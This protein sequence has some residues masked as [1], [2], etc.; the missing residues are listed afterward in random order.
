[1]CYNKIQLS[2][3]LEEAFQR[4]GDF[5]VPPPAPVGNGKLLGVF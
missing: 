4:L 2:A 3:L 5:R 1:M